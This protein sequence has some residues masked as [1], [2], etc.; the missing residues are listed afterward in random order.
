MLEASAGGADARPFTTFHNALQQPYALRIAT[1]KPVPC[2]KSACLCT[3]TAQIVQVAS[4]H[5][6]C[7]LLQGLLQ[8]ICMQLL[9]LQDVL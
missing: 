6:M 7:R 4:W 8:I 9:R 5:L 1:G 2:L 3:L